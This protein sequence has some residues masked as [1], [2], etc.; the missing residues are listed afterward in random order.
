MKLTFKKT[1]DRYHIYSYDDKLSS[2]FSEQEKEWFHR[3]FFFFKTDMDDIYRDVYY[4]LCVPMITKFSSNYSDIIKSA[5]CA[6]VVL[7]H[8]GITVEI[9]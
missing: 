2:D 5:M 3:S 6:K 1:G 8:S 9:I 7:E 4:D